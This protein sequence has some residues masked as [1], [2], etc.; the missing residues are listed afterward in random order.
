MKIQFG[1]FL[2]VSVFLVIWGYGASQW[3]D[4][5]E[6]IAQDIV[7]LLGDRYIHNVLIISRFHENAAS[8]YLILQL[9]LIAFFFFRVLF[10]FVS[11]I[12]NGKR[13]SWAWLSAAVILIFFI[14]FFELM[15]PSIDKLFLPY[16]L[17]FLV[18]YLPKYFVIEFT[19]WCL[20]RGLC[21]TED[22]FK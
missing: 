17:F 10:V 3:L 22:K 12:G 9:I 14:L 19:V 18:N 5:L 2:S 15:V 7:P 1:I 20:R 8:Q 13:H 16:P 4:A 11:L 6:P 21:H